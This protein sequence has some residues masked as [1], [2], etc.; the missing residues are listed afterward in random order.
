MGLLTVNQDTCKQDGLCAAECPFGIILMPEGGT[1]QVM[2]GAEPFCIACGHCVAACP[3][4]ALDHPD[5]MTRD[6][7]PIRKEL[8]VSPEQ[9]EQFMR[10][11]RSIRRYKPE[12][13][14]RA[15][16]ERLLNIARFAQTGHN[17]QGVA[18]KVFTRPEDV[19]A[20]AAHIVDWMRKLVE[21]GEPL[22]AEMS[23]ALICDLFEQGK[24]MVMREA[25]HLVLTHAHRS[26]RFA[27]HACDI[28]MTHVE[29]YA[30]VLG[31]GSC[32]AGFF[33]VAARQ[34]EPLQ[35][36]LALPEGHEV[37]SA[38][39][40]GLPAVRHYRCPER[41]PLQVEWV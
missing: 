20:V 15:D 9:A 39:M 18:W 12:P 7:L 24:D 32:W 35:R 37:M 36:F 1:P 19:R 13:V 30:P 17:S 23:M 5:V 25:P 33:E 21:A 11:R 4:G 26:D 14:P 22:A 28:A 31:L 16:L 6:C 40:V 10:S 38:A 34:W 3:H 8:R 29:L 27:P 41:K 2:E